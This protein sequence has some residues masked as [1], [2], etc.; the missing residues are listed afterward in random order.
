MLN[1]HDCS[2]DDC[3]IDEDDE[4]LQLGYLSNDAGVK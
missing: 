1:G 3:W 4:T 2:E